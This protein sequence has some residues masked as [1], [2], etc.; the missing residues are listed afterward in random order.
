MYLSRSNNYICENNGEA[1][2][3]CDKSALPHAHLHTTNKNRETFNSAN[4]SQN[5]Q[6]SDCTCV[7]FQMNFRCHFTD[8]VLLR[9][10][11]V[12]RSHLYHR[13]CVA[14]VS[15]L[16]ENVHIHHWL[17]AARNHSTDSTIYH[18]TT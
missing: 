15:I 11:C 1:Y 10:D 6:H 8:G 18:A 4:K 12:D 2:A 17:D 14:D 13:D 16:C 5:N 7:R 3:K 9:M